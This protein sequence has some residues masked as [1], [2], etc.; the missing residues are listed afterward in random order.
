VELPLVRSPYVTLNTAVLESVISVACNKRF[1]GIA[2]FA[3]LVAFARHDERTNRPCRSGDIL[4]LEGRTGDHAELLVDGKSRGDID[5]ER[6]FRRCAFG[7]A[8]SQSLASNPNPCLAC[9]GQPF[10]ARALAYRDGTSGA[11]SS[12]GRRV[13]ETRPSPIERCSQVKAL[14]ATEI[15]PPFEFPTQLELGLPFAGARPAGKTL[16]SGICG[17]RRQWNAKIAIRCTASEAE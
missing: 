8:L 16:K 5:V 17:A 9:G 14:R 2:C 1:D 3:A 15:L 10:G 6:E 11:V 4:Y 13:K 12:L 7:C